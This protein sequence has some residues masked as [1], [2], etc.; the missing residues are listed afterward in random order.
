VAYL[1]GNELH[2]ALTLQNWFSINAAGTYLA[3]YT[4]GQTVDLFW[5]IDQASRTLNLVV[6]PGETARLTFDAVSPNGVA[7]TP[8]R[9]IWIDI[10]LHE[11]DA[12]TTLFLDDV[13]VE[14]L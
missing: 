8:L 3:P 10:V 12:N 7:T 14:E 11:F 4:P 2:S 9:R 13:T 1:S 5:S 6:L